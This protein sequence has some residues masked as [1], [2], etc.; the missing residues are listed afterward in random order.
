MWNKISF[1]D[2][3]NFSVLIIYSMKTSLW[4]STK[5]QYQED[6]KEFVYERT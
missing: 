2:L 6:I 4:S 1:I 3:I 5:D